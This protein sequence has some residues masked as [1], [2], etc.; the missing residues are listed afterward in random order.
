MALNDSNSGVL[1]LTDIKIDELTV[2]EIKLT[3]F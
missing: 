3:A 2:L 1:W